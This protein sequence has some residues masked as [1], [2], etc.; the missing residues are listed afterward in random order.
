MDIKNKAEINKTYN[1]NRPSEETKSNS[2]PSTGTIQG[3]NGSQRK[4]VVEEHHGGSKAFSVSPED[5][6]I[7]TDLTKYQ[8]TND[9]GTPIDPK[10][11]FD[12]DIFLGTSSSSVIRDENSMDGIPLSTE[13]KSTLEEPLL[14][15]DEKDLAKYF[16]DYAENKVA[17]QLKGLNPPYQPPESTHQKK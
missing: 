7:L 5:Y 9:D 15:K 4:I 11:F 16:Q 6:L 13:K 14:S 1:L 2:F 17:N 10:K 12:E 8:R 3:R